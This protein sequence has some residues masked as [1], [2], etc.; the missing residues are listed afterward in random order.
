MV[1]LITHCG[2]TSTHTTP[3]NPVVIDIATRGGILSVKRRSTA[4]QL[5]VGSAG[6]R[7]RAK[8]VAGPVVR[9]PKSRAPSPD[10]PHT[11]LDGGHLRPA[12]AV[13]TPIGKNA[14]SG[15]RRLRTR[16]ISQYPQQSL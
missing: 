12:G 6:R 4:L 14:Q 3:T 11:E 16:A 2:P 1:E 13:D 9:R 8:A 7:Q 15:R 5:D 10:C